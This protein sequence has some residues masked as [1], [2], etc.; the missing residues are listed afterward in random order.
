MLDEPSPFRDWVFYVD[1]ILLLLFVATLLQRMTKPQLKRSTG[2]GRVLQLCHQYSVGR[3][4]VVELRSASV[5][6]QTLVPVER[7]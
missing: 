6:T 3:S 5:I 7:M 4:M 2:Q 1:T